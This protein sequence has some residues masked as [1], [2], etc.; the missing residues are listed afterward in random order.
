MKIKVSGSKDHMPVYAQP[1]DAGADLKSAESIY[2]PPL[3]RLMVTTGIKLEIPEG[4][5]GLIHPRSGLALKHGITVLNSPGTIDS[6]YRGEIGVILFNTTNKPFIINQGD[7]IA[8]LVIQ[9][10]ET[11][12]FEF[13]DVLDDTKRGDGGFGSTGVSDGNEKVAP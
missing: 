5:V 6:G 11:A 2:I 8:Q 10:V 13:V 12:E 4:Y 9:K 3:E 1:G 7:R